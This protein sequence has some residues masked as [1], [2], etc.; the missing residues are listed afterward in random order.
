MPDTHCVCHTIKGSCWISRRTAARRMMMIIVCEGEAGNYYIYS[1]CVFY[2]NYDFLWSQLV[3]SQKEGKRTEERKNCGCN[4]FCGFLSVWW[5]VQTKLI[6]MNAKYMRINLVIGE[7]V[8]MS[9]CRVCDWRGVAKLL[10]RTLFA[11]E[12]CFGGEFTVAK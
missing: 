11:C 5:D 10:I 1:G 2:T 8:A 3:S 7:H 12:L 4:L 9:E 6:Q